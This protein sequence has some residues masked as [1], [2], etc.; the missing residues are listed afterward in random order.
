MRLCNSKLNILRLISVC[1]C[2]DV[3]Y[4][5][6]LIR[7]TSP[8]YAHYAYRQ[9]RSCCALRYVRLGIATTYHFVIRCVFA[10]IINRSN[11]W[12]NQEW[13]SRSWIQ[14]TILC[15]CD[16]WCSRI[17]SRINPG[18]TG[19]LNENNDAQNSVISFENRVYSDRQSGSDVKV[20]VVYSTWPFRNGSL[21]SRIQVFNCSR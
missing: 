15:Y 18:S 4:V 3:L 8:G 5:N 2:N 19:T 12:F 6:H 10:Q 20:H 14:S 13:L 1:S 9:K 11:I 17:R 16:I 7:A 21:N